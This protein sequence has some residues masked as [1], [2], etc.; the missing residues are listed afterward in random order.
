MSSKVISDLWST[1]A[2]KRL[3]ATKRIWKEMESVSNFSLAK[4]GEIRTNTNNQI[5]TTIEEVYAGNGIH[6]KT[7]R[8]RSV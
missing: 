6:S 1:S 8:K 7:M 5:Y 3:V 2:R 4:I